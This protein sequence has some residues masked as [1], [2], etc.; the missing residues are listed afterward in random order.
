VFFVG[1]LFTAPHPRICPQ[2]A[3]PGAGGEDFGGVSEGGG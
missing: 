2:E 3:E 1:Y